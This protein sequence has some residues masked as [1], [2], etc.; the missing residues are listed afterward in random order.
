MKDALEEDTRIGRRDEYAWK[1]KAVG[2]DGDDAAYLA[3]A[4]AVGESELL[5]S[6]G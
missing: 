1:W 4:I 6:L 5:L 3:V 2:V